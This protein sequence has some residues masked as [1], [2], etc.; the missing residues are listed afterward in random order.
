MRVW[1]STSAHAH[2][3]FLGH[4]SSKKN[5][6]NS[7]TRKMCPL[8]ITIS[9]SVWPGWI[10]AFFCSNAPSGKKKSIL[11]LSF[12]EINSYRVEILLSV[13]SRFAF[14]LIHPSK[15]L[16]SLWIYICHNNLGH[17]L[18]WSVVIVICEMNNI[19]SLIYLR[20]APGGFSI[21]VQFSPL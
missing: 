21:S 10:F 14:L 1:M 16:L 3:K 4:C 13:G 18:P 19:F 9:C 15:L 2:A 11:K 8:A 6:N 7:L 5:S 17:W 20:S 12:S